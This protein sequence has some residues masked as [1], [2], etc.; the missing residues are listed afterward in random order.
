MVV[1]SFGWLKWKGN[2][3]DRYVFK[4]YQIDTFGVFTNRYQCPP[5]PSS[6]PPPH[7][8]ATSAAPPPLFHNNNHTHHSLELS[9]NKGL[10]TPKA[11]M[12]EQVPMPPYFLLVRAIR[13][14][15]RSKEGY[16][17]LFLGCKQLSCTNTHTTFHQI[18]MYL[19]SVLYSKRE[20]KELYGKFESNFLYSQLCNV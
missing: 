2:S 9:H 13:A 20:Q 11:S 19:F 15:I 17:C 3:L 5:P 10:L 8:N 4:N 1:F 16:I 12:H 6:L 14:E 7:L 18:F